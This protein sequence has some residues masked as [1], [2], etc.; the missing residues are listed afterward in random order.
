MSGT[1]A[2]SPRPGIAKPTPYATGPEGQTAPENFDG[3]DY[4][5]E[6]NEEYEQAAEQITRYIRRVKKILSSA[7]F[8]GVLGYVGYSRRGKRAEVAKNIEHTKF[9]KDD[10]GLFK[11]SERIFCEYTDPKTN[12]AKVILPASIVKDGT[13]KKIQNLEIKESDIIVASF[14]KAG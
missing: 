7:L 5:E 10:Q 13:I 6:K 12:G 11:G 8:V 4:D 1:S 9:L 3:G 2:Q 14:P